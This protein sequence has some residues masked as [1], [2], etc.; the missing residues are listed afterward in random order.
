MSRV[1]I[2]GSSRDPKVDWN[3]L[4]VD[5][6]V[7]RLTPG[8]I[9][10]LLDECDPDDPQFPPSMRSNYRCEKSETGPL[11]RKKLLDFINDQALNTPDIPEAVPFVQGTV[12]GK[13]WTP[14][15]KP[16]SSD[17]AFDLGDGIELDI[18]LGD[19]AE[20]ALKAANTSDVIDLA[21]ILGLHSMMNQDQYHSAQSDKWADTPDPTV[22]WNGVTKATPLKAFPAEEPNRTN[23]DDIIVCLK[24]NDRST[25]SANLNNVPMSE[26]KLLELFEAMRVNKTLIELKIA[27]TTMGDFAA[28][29]LAAALECNTNLEKLNIES[30]NVSPQCL[31]KIFE[32]ANVQQVLSDIKASNQQAQ[33]LGNRV[34]MA[35][36]KA[37]E[38]N[39]AMLKVGLH[40]EFGDCRNRLAVQLQ[41]NLDRVRLKRIQKKLS[42]TQNPDGYDIS[43]HPSGQLIA[44]PKPREATPGTDEDDIS[45]AR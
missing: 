12:R 8:E 45:G 44:T 33:F 14:P 26:E 41:K 21:G 19:A 23:P 25:A 35:I 20:T 10:K 28:A 22:G 31:V 27:N 18:D 34:E 40:F 36:T 42:A 24:A 5:E 32:A 39:R 6:L 7:D 30:N 29:N 1:T 11:D 3:E 16:Q 38:G 43:S 37:V 9:Q 2:T 13:K 4:D 17:A 15:P